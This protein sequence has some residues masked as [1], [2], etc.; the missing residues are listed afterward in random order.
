MARI[1]VEDSLL[2]DQRFLD[3]AIK[4]GSVQH[5][6][7]AMV[8]AWRQG[9][10]HYLS[11]D[12]ERCIPFD[13]WSKQRCEDAIITVG[14]AMKREKGIWIVGADK[15]FGW[16]EQRQ[17]AGEKS[18]KSRKKA[19]KAPKKV[20]RPLTTVGKIDPKSNGSQPLS[21]FLLSLSSNQKLNLPPSVL[22]S[23]VDRV[24]DEIYPRKIGL[25]KGREALL[26]EIKT[27]G[28]IT[29]FYDAAVRYAD[30]V[31]DADNDV[32]NI[33]GFKGFV[34]VWKEWKPGAVKLQ[35]I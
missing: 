10:K 35:A 19:E 12:T 33:Y 24:Y 11:V 17:K 29:D 6:L 13:E 30:Y 14:L 3:L 20:E 21:S 34:D 16:L 32:K 22:S 25:V 1:N 7:G 31:A 9:Q 2:T 18:A 27:A 5:A 4:L 15:Q 8:W 23:L 28:D 26:L